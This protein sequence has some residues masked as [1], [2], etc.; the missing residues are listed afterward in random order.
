MTSPS[1]KLAVYRQ[2]A[3]SLRYRLRD[4]ERQT[5]AASAE[6]RELEAKISGF[7]EALEL[8]QPAK[9]LDE[10]TRQRKRN[11][12]LTGPWQTIMQA[13]D[14]VAD[15]FSYEDLEAAARSINHEITRDTLRSQMSLYKNSGLVEAGA[16]VG[17]F[18]LTDAGRRAAGIA[19]DVSESDDDKIAIIRPLSPCAGDVARM[20][21]HPSQLANNL[22]EATVAAVAAVA[23]NSLANGELDVTAP[24]AKYKFKYSSNR[25]SSPEESSLDDFM[26]KLGGA[27]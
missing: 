11:R 22:E 20:N 2:K 16:L 25:R 12:P 18:H 17:T 26:N 3:N 1:D 15:E 9:S 27:E 21:R 13:V 23:R 4:L 14:M 24:R 8:V 10:A 6:L 19:P 7:L 5:A